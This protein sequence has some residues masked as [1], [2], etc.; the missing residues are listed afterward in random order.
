M[1]VEPADEALGAA[2][3]GTD[4]FAK[5]RDGEAGFDFFA[6]LFKND[7]LRPVGVDRGVADAVDDFALLV[8][9]V[10]VLQQAFA[11][12]EVLLLHLLLRAFDGAVEPRML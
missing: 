7:L 5:A 4:F 2:G 11:D 10:V 3:S 1:R 8:E 12:G 6:H 9:H